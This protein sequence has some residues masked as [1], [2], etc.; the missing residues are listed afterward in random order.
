MHAKVIEAVVHSRRALRQDAV[1]VVVLSLLCLRV[2]RA[3]TR[4]VA[5][6]SRVQRAL[7]QVGE[8]RILVRPANVICR[9]LEVLDSD[10]L[11]VVFIIEDHLVN[12]YLLLDLPLHGLLLF[13]FLLEHALLH[14][15]EQQGVLLRVLAELRLHADGRQLMLEAGFLG[16]KVASDVL[17][18]GRGP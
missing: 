16:R 15:Q 6:Q 11:I 1:G 7:V 10:L 3:G 12:L 17:W 4:L 18:R 14:L 2:L 13:E 5:S 9:P 8:H